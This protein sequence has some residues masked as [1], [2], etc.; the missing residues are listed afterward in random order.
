M[1]GAVWAQAELR[2]VLAT[3]GARVVDRELPIANA[4]EAFDAEGRMVEADQHDEL[5]S[6]LEAL[7]TEAQPRF[8]TAA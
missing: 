2:K 3:A 5:A 4:D 8:A 6:I 7:A 1:F